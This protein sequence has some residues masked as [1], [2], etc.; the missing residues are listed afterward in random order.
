[1]RSYLNVKPREPP[2]KNPPKFEPPSKIWSWLTIKGWAA[3]AL[4][5]TESRYLLQFFCLFVSTKTWW[6]TPK[7]W[8]SSSIF[9]SYTLKE[10]CSPQKIS[11]YFHFLN[12]HTGIS[13]KKKLAGRK[14]EDE[15]RHRTREQERIEAVVLMIRQER[16]LWDEIRNAGFKVLMNHPQIWFYTITEVNKNADKQTNTWPD[17]MVP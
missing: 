10:E 4:L 13:A 2:S 16:V 9:P 8:C 1:M 15:G 3:I 5:G 11:H 14:L 12:E 6:R 17:M 7:H